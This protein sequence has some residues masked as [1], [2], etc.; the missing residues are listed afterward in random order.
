M[1]LGASR[2]SVRQLVLRQGLA[3]VVAGVVLGVAGAYGFSRL[4][5]RYL[6]ATTPADASAYAAAAWSSWVPR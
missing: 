1:A 6:F 3:L 2:G 5:A 4:I